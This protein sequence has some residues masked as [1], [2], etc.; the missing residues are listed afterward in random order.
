M[1][2]IFHRHIVRAWFLI[3]V[4]VCLYPPLYWSAGNIQVFILGLPASFIYFMSISISVTLSILYAY[5][6]ESNSE[7]L[8]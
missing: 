6:E 8:Q 4:F 1:P 2:N 3:N 7:E 5:G